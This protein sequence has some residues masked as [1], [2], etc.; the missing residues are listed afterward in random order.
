LAIAIITL[1]TSIIILLAYA[2]TSN[3]TISDGST[4]TNGEFLMLPVLTANLRVLYNNATIWDGQ[5]AEP[6]D[7]SGHGKHQ[8]NLLSNQLFLTQI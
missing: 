2:T 8:T 6:D 5:N 4:I 7:F 1:I 3:L